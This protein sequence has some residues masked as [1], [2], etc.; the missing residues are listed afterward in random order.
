MDKLDYIFYTDPADVK[1]VDD[2]ERSVDFRFREDIIAMFE[3]LITYKMSPAN[4]EKIVRL[5]GTVEERMNFIGEYLN[6]K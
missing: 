5:S 4:R 6:G 2:G 1:L 3:D